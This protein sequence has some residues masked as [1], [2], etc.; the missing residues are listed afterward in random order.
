[1][2]A[3]API[4]RPIAIRLIST[5]R[6]TPE[7]PAPLASSPDRRAEQPDRTARPFGQGLR[8]PEH[9]ARHPTAAWNADRGTQAADKTKAEPVAR[10]GLGPPVRPKAGRRMTSCW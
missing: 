4:T 6:D 9:N 3:K 8:K 10:L 7:P 5:D 2:T 1:M